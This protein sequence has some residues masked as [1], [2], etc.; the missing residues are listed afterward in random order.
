MNN[1]I[2]IRYGKTVYLLNFEEIMYLEADG[3]Y[4]HIST[5]KLKLTTCK[6][7]GA[8]EKKLSFEF[9]RIHNKYIV[10]SIFIKRIFNEKLVLINDDEIP[11]SIR[12][13]KSLK[14][15]LK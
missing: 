8:L 11:I 7:I 4:T 6:N 5:G 10:N 14:D 15:M 13:R 12:K 2:L 9:I 1:R 3:R